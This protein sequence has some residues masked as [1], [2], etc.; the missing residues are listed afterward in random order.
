MAPLI[1]F[2]P[3][4]IAWGDVATW[5]AGIGALSA[6]VVAVCIALRDGRTRRKERTHS[7]LIF[8]LYIIQEL[9]QLRASL[10][11]IRKRVAAVIDLKDAQ[12]A[13]N[14]WPSITLM[15]KSLDLPLLMASS[16]R[17]TLLDGDDAKFVA[18]TVAGLMQL[19]SAIAPWGMKEADVATN[20]QAL[21]EPMRVLIVNLQRYVNGAYE[22]IWAIAEPK[23]NMP[24]DE[25]IDLSDDEMKIL[26][27][28][29]QSGGYEPKLGESG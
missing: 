2:C 10:P 28:Y 1:E 27:K 19:R 12:T 3:E 13:T 14:N 4:K 25:D 5:I 7:A 24:V 6:S 29:D 15:V 22:R 23:S 26:G 11:R 21:L 16:D 8:S 9:G 20:A 18:A 17:I